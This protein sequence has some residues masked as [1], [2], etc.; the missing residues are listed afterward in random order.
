MKSLARRILELGDEIA[1]LDELIGPIVAALAPHMPARTG[2]GIE[3]VGQLLVTAGDNRH[4]LRAED[5]WGDAP[6]RRP[7]LPT[8]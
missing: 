2:M 7:P 8:M 4:R 5:R 3:V 1:M 6:R